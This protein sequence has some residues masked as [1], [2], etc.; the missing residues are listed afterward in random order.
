VELRVHLAGLVD[1]ALARPESRQTLEL[2]NP[3]S[4]RTKIHGDVR[5]QVLDMSDDLLRQTNP[6]ISAVREARLAQTKYETPS[7]LVPRPQRSR[8][9]SQLRRFGVVLWFGIA[10][11]IAV[12]QSWYILTRH[13]PGFAVVLID[14]AAAVGLLI[15]AS[16]IHRGIGDN[17]PAV[18]GP[19]WTFTAGVGAAYRPLPGRVPAVRRQSRY[20]RR[21]TED[22][23]REHHPHQCPTTSSSRCWPR[24]S[25]SWTPSARMSSS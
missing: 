24:P 3:A 1:E 14:I 19:G 13:L 4:D 25:T 17:M 23:G 10:F 2:I 12:W 18:N 7:Y 6:E 11:P 21:R 8:R 9:R 15:L 22:A 20:G 5:R 16:P